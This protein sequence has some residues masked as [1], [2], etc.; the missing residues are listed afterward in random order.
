MKDITN[1]SPRIVVLARDQRKHRL[2]KEFRETWYLDQLEKNVV[3]IV[4]SASSTHTRTTGPIKNE[5]QRRLIKK[6]HPLPAQTV[7]A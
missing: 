5:G 2:E 7:P 3:L 4:N 1:T 6:S